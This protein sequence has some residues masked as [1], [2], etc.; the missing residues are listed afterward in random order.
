MTKDEKFV[1][2]KFMF[3]DFGVKLADTANIILN[4]LKADTSLNEEKIINILLEYC[5]IGEIQTK[6]II[7]CPLCND[8]EGDCV[9]CE[10]LV[11]EIKYFK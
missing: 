6:L 3:E 2:G 4:D 1:K 8:S 5:K 7:P 9:A 11:E 10:E